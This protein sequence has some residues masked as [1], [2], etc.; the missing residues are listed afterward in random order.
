MTD[1]VHHHST[2][3]WYMRPPLWVLG[4]VL[5]SLAAFGIVEI[6]GRPAPTP[7]SAFLDQLDAGN[8]TSIILREC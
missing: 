3:P 1:S 8:V 2:R 7:Y 4:I 6:I 5:V